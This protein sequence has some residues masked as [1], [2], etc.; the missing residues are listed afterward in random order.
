MNALRGNTYIAR[1]DFAHLWVSLEELEA[2]AA[3]WSENRGLTHLGL[4][5]CTVDDHCWDTLTGAIAEHP[6]W[7]DSQPMG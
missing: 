2:L 4:R 6:W 3:T 5:Y 1:L 7:L